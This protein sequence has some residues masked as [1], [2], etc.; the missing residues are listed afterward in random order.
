MQKERAK[1]NWGIWGLAIVAGATLFVRGLPN[2]TVGHQWIVLT[3]A[4]VLHPKFRAAAVKMHIVPPEISFLLIFATAAAAFFGLGFTAPFQ[5][6]NAD[7]GIGKAWTGF[8]V[9]LRI[10]W[11]VRAWYRGVLPTEYL[12]LTVDSAFPKPTRESMGS[13]PGLPQWNLDSVIRVLDRVLHEQ[14][15][16]HGQF[17]LREVKNA[18]FSVEVF[19]LV[20][21]YIAKWALAEKLNVDPTRLD[22]WEN[23]VQ[24]MMEKTRLCQQDVYFI[25][26][27]VAEEVRYRRFLQ[28]IG[29]PRP[30]SIERL[31]ETV[32]L[33]DQKDVEKGH[34][35]P[36]AWVKRYSAL[37]DWELSA[38]VYNRSYRMLLS[39]YKENLRITRLREYENSLLKNITDKHADKPMQVSINVANIVSEDK[40]VS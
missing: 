29:K 27:Y 32:M 38:D 14:K 4:A 22:D 10:G 1:R 18:L 39:K 12:G 40:K 24:L 11:A 8:V 23:F 9:F 37:L 28:E 16:Q 26:M 36:F 25:V 21:C 17:N 19:E 30:E 3:I 7:I 2:S 34:Q 15:R 31:V 33:L 6:P 20:D 5:S 35:I 13:D